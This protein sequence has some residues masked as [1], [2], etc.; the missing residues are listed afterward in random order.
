VSTRIDLKAGRYCDT[1]SSSFILPC[2]IIIIAA[3]DGTALVI[4]AMRKIESA[5]SGTFFPASCF[6]ERARIEVP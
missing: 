4:E 5:A 3:T 1:S 6:A 2:S